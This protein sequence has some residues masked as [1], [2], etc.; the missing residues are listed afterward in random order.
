MHTASLTQGVEPQLNSLHRSAPQP[1]P[2]FGIACWL[3]ALLAFAQLITV[4]TAL[5]VRSN[6]PVQ[7]QMVTVVDA[8]KVIEPIAPRTV[9][10]I[11]ADMSPAVPSAS[12]AHGLLADHA[13]LMPAPVIPQ[14]VPDV[15]PSRAVSVIA[16]PRVERL[17]QESRNLYLEGDMMRAMLKL[18][19][20][21]RIDPNE[22]AVIY[23][24]GILFEGMGIFTQAADQ[25]VQIQQ[26]G[27]VKAGRY[28][29]MA[30]DKLTKGMYTVSSRRSTLAIGPMKLNKG[31]GADSARR[32]EV[33]VTLLARPDIEVLPDDVEVQVH[34]YDKVNGGDV[35]KAASN[36]EIL[37]HW[38]DAKVDWRDAGNE[39]TLRVS[40]TIP[41]ADLAEQHLLGRREFYGC[42][43]ELLYKGE[44]IDQQARPRN[45]HSIHSGLKVP[46]YHD[47]LGLPWLPGDDNSLL[48]GK[49]ETLD[50]YDRYA[51]L[52]IR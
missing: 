29:R 38:S 33:A 12:S 52:P 6:Q 19:E 51:P 20:A 34:F 44:V 31:A 8:P 37:S 10:Q 39:E 14:A 5:A 24:K 11:L 48:P 30:A 43:V 27:L 3:L 40:Y 32:A 25:Y 7:R 47:D 1:R 2:T 50:D 21:G 18:E 15:A 46:A 9:A 17:V 35:K 45:L 49:E 13:P 23:Q 22:C 42:V 36:A 4:G 41:Q 26:M 16:N 28:Y